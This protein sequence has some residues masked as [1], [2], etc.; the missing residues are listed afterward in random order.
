MAHFTHAFPEL[1]VADQADRRFK[2]RRTP[3][4][5]AIAFMRSIGAF[6]T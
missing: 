4:A 1:A 3:P 5:Q 2:D 6:E